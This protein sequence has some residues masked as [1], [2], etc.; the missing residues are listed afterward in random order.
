MSRP[1]RHLIESRDCCEVRTRCVVAKAVGR[2]IEVYWH[3]DSAQASF[4]AE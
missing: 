2:T 4:Y 1:Y 3:G